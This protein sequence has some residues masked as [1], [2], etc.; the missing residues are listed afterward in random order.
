M[1]F[2]KA[3]L[4]DGYV[5]EIPKFSFSYKVDALRILCNVAKCGSLPSGSSLLR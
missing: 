5:L 4:K 1:G 3:G 2:V